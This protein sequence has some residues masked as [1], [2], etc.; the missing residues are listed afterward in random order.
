MNGQD[1]NNAEC[2]SPQRLEWLLEHHAA[3]LELYARQFCRCGEDIVQEAV[4]ELAALPQ[5]PRDD[6]AWLY[7]VVR[8]KAI[9]AG[10]SEQRRKR[11]EDRAAEGRTEWFAGL[12][13]R[14]A[15]ARLAAAALETLPD[16]QREIVVAHVWGG[17]TFQQIG[18]VLGTGASTAHRQYQA[19]LAA[20]RTRLNLPCPKNS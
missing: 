11:R 9:S 20:I 10:R 17:L 7:G 18:Q 1:D 3:A 5:P 12:A 14:T 2:V 13:E 16:A 19:A 4:I 8:H 6:V 15:E